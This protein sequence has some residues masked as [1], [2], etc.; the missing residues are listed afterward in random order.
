MNLKLLNWIFIYMQDIFAKLAYIE[1]VEDQH[2]G[3]KKCFLLFIQYCVCLNTFDRF[4]KF[5]KTLYHYLFLGFI[6]FHGSNVTDV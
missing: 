6:F 1:H 4:W 2:L 3:I 5:K